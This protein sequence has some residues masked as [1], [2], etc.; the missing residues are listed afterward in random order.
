MST[1]EM[2]QDKQPI[3]M[4]GLTATMRDALGA[5]DTYAAAA[6]SGARGQL[7]GEDGRP[8]RKAF[9][10]HQ[11]LAHGLSWLVTYVETLRIPME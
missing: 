7:A 11:H 2:V 8:D 10:R 9:E 4:E 3:V 5:L 1:G 6:T